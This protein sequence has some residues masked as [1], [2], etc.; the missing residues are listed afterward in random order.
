MAFETLGPIRD[1]IV[2]A[3]AGARVDVGLALDDWVTNTVGVDIDIYVDAG[4]S[5]D[6]GD[7]TTKSIQLK[8]GSRDWFYSTGGN[9]VAMDPNMDGSDPDVYANSAECAAFLAA[10][11]GIETDAAVILQA[12]LDAITA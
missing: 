8:T 5:T 1:G 6:P 2:A 3:V 4:F 10:V 7:G 11:P 12:H 9:K